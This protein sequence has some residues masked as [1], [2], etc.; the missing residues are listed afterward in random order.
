[1]TASSSVFI[2]STCFLGM[3]FIILI[4]LSLMIYGASYFPM[5][6]Y[7][8]SLTTGGGMNFFFLLTGLLL[9]PQPLLLLL[10]GVLDSLT[11]YRLALVV[12]EDWC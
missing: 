5:I 4:M 7:S 1:M 11:Y 12:I 9:T 6:I 2:P 8:S 3:G 10:W